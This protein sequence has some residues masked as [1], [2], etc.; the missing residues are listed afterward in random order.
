MPRT[1]SRRSARAAPT[2]GVQDADNL[3]WK[4]ALRAATA[5]APDALLDTYAS[6]REYAADENILQLD[7]RDRLHHAEERRQPRCSATRC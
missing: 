6:E 3:A 4:L 7:A 1:A 5:S 2:S